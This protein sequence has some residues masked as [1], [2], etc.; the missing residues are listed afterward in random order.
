MTRDDL[1]STALNNPNADQ[2]ALASPIYNP[3][4][5]PIELSLINL[6]P[7]PSTDP[8]LIS[9]YTNII[10][11][12]PTINPFEGVLTNPRG[13]EISQVKTDLDD[14]RT[15]LTNLQ[16]LITGSDIPLW[17]LAVP[18]IMA[19]LNTA[20]TTMNTFEDHTNRSIA[21]LPN[22]LGMAQSA[23]GLAT[24]VAGLISPCSGITGMLGSIMKQGQALMAQVMS[25]VSS[26]GSMIKNA[27]NEVT[28][29][30]M[31]LLGSNFSSFSNILSSINSAMNKVMS[32][33][34]AVTDMVGKE[35][36][37]MIASLIGAARQGL[38]G[39]LASL[40]SDPCLKGLI[41]SVTSGP[42]SQL[43][44]KI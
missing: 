23:A 8:A 13:C 12:M 11:S 27:I 7:D 19:D 10:K 30:I 28:H 6:M 2:E 29:G 43:L 38:A 33:I 24:A 15:D 1:I 22:I 36:K 14:I 34:R 40:P 18:G 41:G 20:T 37:N 16:T 5:S 44:S 25:A 26:V 42:A 39:L 21:N 17:S 32:G 9:T 4:I 3:D 35:I 31:G